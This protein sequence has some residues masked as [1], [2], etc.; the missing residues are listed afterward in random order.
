MKIRT[1]LWLLLPLLAFSCGGDDSEN[2]A[3][4]TPDT[5]QNEEPDQPE[6]PD[7]GTDG[8]SDEDPEDSDGISYGQRG[9][10][11]FDLVNRYYRIQN[12]SAA[13]LYVENYNGTTGSSPSYLWGYDGLISGV[14]TLHEL[15]YEVDYEAMVDRF[16]AY[17]RT[18]GAVNVGGYGSATDG[19]YGSGDRY[20]DDNA[21]VGLDLVEAYELTGEQKYLDRAKRIVAFLHSGEDD[22]FGGG[23]WWNESLKNNPNDGNS[24]KP[25]CSNGFATLFLLRYYGVCTME[26]KVDVLAFAR[27]LYEWLVAN[28]RDPSDGCYWNDKSAAGVINQTKWAYNTGVMISCG[29]RLY[30]ITADPAYLDLARESADGA[31]RC[32][33][34]PAGSLTQA[35]PDHDPWFTIKLVRSYMD[36]APYH[37]PAKEYI[38][39]FIRYLDHAWQYARTPEGLF[40][41]NWTGVSPGRSEQLLMQGAALESLGAVALYR[42]ETAQKSM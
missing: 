6:D 33:V 15:G 39:I 27:R 3:P 28:L 12:G 24:N 13:G 8:G 41:E 19:R 26:E 22:I 40:Y 21:I 25:T 35:Y 36:L 7:E 32:F 18:S 9:L 5:D 38:D 30:R 1:F 4:Q 37:E 31:Y 42:G 16:E 11:F 29:V 34:G 23:L 10:E 17:Y 20:Y 14:A 2:A